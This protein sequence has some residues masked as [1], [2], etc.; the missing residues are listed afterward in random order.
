MKI[1]KG[2]PI[3][4]YCSY[5]FDET[6]PK[7]YTLADYGIVLRVE[8]NA[9][10]IQWFGLKGDRAYIDKHNITEYDINFRYDGVEARNRKLN[11]VLDL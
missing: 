1:K 3:V 9:I 10:Q 4:W 8:S 2:D 5:S 6:I 7:E 11:E